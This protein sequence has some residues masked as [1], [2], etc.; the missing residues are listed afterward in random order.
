MLSD[1]FRF[2]SCQLEIL[3]RCL[4]Q[5]VRGTLAELP[6]SLDETYERILHH[7]PR[8]NRVYAHRLLQCLSVAL[9]PLCVEELVEVL[10][11]DFSATGGIPKVDETLRWEGQEQAVLSACSSLITIVAYGGSRLVQFSH[12]SIKEF[13]TSD[14]LAA[15]NE[16]ALRCHHI[17]PQP[18]HMIMAQACLAVLLHLDKNMNEN[19]LSSYPLAKYAA[20]HFSVH[21]EFNDVLS[22][23]V[24][25]V[26]ALL[27]PNKPYFDIWV[28]L[29][30]GD[31]TP[32]TWH[33]AKPRLILQSATFYSMPEYPPRVAPLYYLAALGYLSLTKH[34]ISKRPQELELKDDEGCTPLHIA[35]LAGRVEVSQLI[36]R[37]SMDLDVR[38]VEGDNLLHMAAWKRRFE[39]A[40]MLLEHEAMKV[41]VNMP[42]G[43]GRTP[44]HIASEY[45]HPGIVAL[46]LKF[47]ADVDAQDYDNTTPLLHAIQFYGSGEAARV[48]LEHGAKFH[49]RDPDGRTPLHLAS[50]Q[51]HTSVVASLLNIGA[52]VDARDNDNMTPLHLASSSWPSPL[53]I[54][55]LLL[56]HRANIHLKDNQGKTPLQ[57][58]REEWQQ[59]IKQLFSQYNQRV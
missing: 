36:L 10:A 20:H 37:H 44:L 40:Q 9:R 21:A 12:F 27:N 17:L 53:E 56:K 14:R 6:E 58:A 13:L 35:V 48:L 25:G 30:I 45:D 7:I 18:A 26:D 1:R 24:D 5:T 50:C 15:S 31:W 28:W 59:D 54:I 51:N 52:D 2:V 11:I 3:R 23:I 55:E 4:P 34:L 49:V 47:D 16:D 39:V 43:R 46:L 32:E 19:A 8:S 41:F 22:H 42:N 33:S 29:Q 57:V 38:D